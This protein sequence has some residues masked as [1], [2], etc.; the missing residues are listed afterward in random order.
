MQSCPLPNFA[1]LLRGAIGGL[2][3]V[4]KENVK[5]SNHSNSDASKGRNNIQI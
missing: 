4:I 2:L 3:K 5:I 1:D